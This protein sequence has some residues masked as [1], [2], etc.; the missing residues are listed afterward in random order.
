MTEEE[1]VVDTAAV[2]AAVDSATR[3]CSE[4]HVMIAAKAVRF[5]SSL[6]AI[7]QS[8]AATALSAMAATS[9]EVSPEVSPEVDSEAEDATLGVILADVVT[10]RCSESL[11]TSV[12]KAVRFPLSQAAISQSI[13]VIA[14]DR[15]AEETVQTEVVEAVNCLRMPTSNSS[16]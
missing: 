11:A 1:E 8:I 6:P 4:L 7:S 15:I 2:E 10:R 16:L 3:R 9:L 12:A 14:L 13:A 5:R